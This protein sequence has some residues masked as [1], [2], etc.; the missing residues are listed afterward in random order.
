MLVPV[1]YWM[2]LRWR[3]RVSPV[4]H[5]SLREG[6]DAGDSDDDESDDETPDNEDP[7]EARQRIIRRL[8]I[9][10]SNLAGSDT[11]Q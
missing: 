1:Y 2:P 10:Y 9:Q 3:G 5:S 6:A 4:H 7:D 8:N 11:V